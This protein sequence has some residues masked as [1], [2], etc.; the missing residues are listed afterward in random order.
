MANDLVNDDASDNAMILPNPQG[1][2]YA[3]AEDKDMGEVVEV[4]ER[5]QKILA[6][7]ICTPGEYVR[8]RHPILHLR[9]Y[10]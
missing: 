6:T 10:P 8:R 2:L 3:V 1:Q 4:L 9:H 7:I 5:R